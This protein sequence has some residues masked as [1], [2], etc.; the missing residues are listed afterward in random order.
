MSNKIQMKRKYNVK[1][2]DGS[3][4]FVKAFSHEF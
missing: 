1:E 3:N 2:N 4:R